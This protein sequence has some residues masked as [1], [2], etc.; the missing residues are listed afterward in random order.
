MW[1][2]GSLNLLWCENVGGKVDTFKGCQWNIQ[3]E[4]LLRLS[5]TSQVSNGST[6]HTEGT[7]ASHSFF[8]LFPSVFITNEFLEIKFS[9]QQ[10]TFPE[11]RKSWK[12][13]LRYCIAWHIKESSCSSFGRHSFGRLF[14]FGAYTMRHSPQDLSKGKYDASSV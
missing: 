6:Q 12:D 13:H 4:F 7:T 10:R 3:G 5:V 11:V 1:S 9:G 8:M 14:L 2:F